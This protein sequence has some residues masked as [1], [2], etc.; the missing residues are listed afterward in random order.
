MRWIVQADQSSD[1][2]W[3]QLELRSESRVSGKVLGPSSKE[4]G[5]VDELKLRV[6]EVML[7]VPVLVLLVFRSGAKKKTGMSV[8]G[9]VM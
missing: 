3:R 5:K 9:V 1:G 7:S 4:Q 2:D 6:R 8:R